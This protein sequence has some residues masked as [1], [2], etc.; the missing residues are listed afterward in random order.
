MD[1]EFDTIQLRKINKFQRLLAMMLCLVMM[2]SLCGADLISIVLAT[3][4]AQQNTAEETRTETR[5]DVK[6]RLMDQ[7]RYEGW[8]PYSSDMTLDEFYALM[9]LFDE[10]KLPLD[11]SV[12]RGIAALG[13]AGLAIDEEPSVNYIPRT[14]FMFR[15]LPLDDSVE[16]QNGDEPISYN[17]VTGYEN[18]LTNYPPGLDNYGSGYQVPPTNWEGVMLGAEKTQVVIVADGQNDDNYNIS[19]NVIQSLFKNYM[20]YGYYVRRVTVEST[21]VAVLGAIKLSGEDGYVYYYLTDENQNTDVST[22]KLED[23]KK[24]I[25]EYSSIE[26]TVQYEVHMDKLDGED[27]TAER[28]DANVLGA[29]LNDTWENIIFGT[30]HLNKTDG[31]AYSFTAYAPYGYTVEFYLVR[32]NEETGTGGSE[33]GEPELLLGMDTAG[34]FT[35]VN[36]GW[37][38]GVEP[39]YYNGSVISDSAAIAPSANGPATLTMSGNIFNNGVHHDRKIIAVVHKNEQPVFLVAPLKFNTNNVSGRGTS[40]TTQVTTAGGETI[41]YDYEDVYLWANG[42]NREKYNLSGLNTTASEG[43][44]RDGNVATNDRWNWSSGG[45]LKDG[46]VY[47][48]EED[49]GTYSYQW[50]WQT[51]DGSGGYTL[52]SLEI[53]GVAVTIPF[54]P[55]QSIRPDYQTGTTGGSTAWYTEAD[56]GNGIHIKVEFLMVFNPGGVAQ[57]VYRITATGARSNVT[58]SAMNLIQ[59]TGADEFVTYHLTGVTDDTGT[60]SVEYYN[61]GE[62]WKSTPQGNIT[63]YQNGTALDLNGDGDHY[64]ANFRFKL[65]DGYT[66]PYYLWEGMQTGEVIQDQASAKRDSD[67]N[68]IL[69]ELNPVISLDGFTGTLDSSNVYGPDA[70]GWYYIRVTTQGGNKVALLTIGAKQLRYVVRYIPNTVEVSNPV[71]VPTFDHTDEPDFEISQEYAEQ[72]DT[73]N[74]SYY[75]VTVDNVIVL[76]DALPSDPSSNYKFVDWV[77][78]DLEGKPITDKQTGAE[79]HYRITHINLLEVV[80][81]AF[82][83]DSL[84][85]AA[86]DIY[87]LR[88]MPKWEPIEH[89]FTYKIALNWVDA[90]GSVH[91]ELYED[92]GS[93]LTDWD[94]ENGPLAV[95]VFKDAAPFKEW[96]LRHPTYSF[97]DAVN[98]ATEKA[99]VTA[100]LDDYVR[101][102]EGVS[103]GDSSYQNILDSLNNM[104]YGGESG[105]PNGTDD[106]FRIG[107]DDPFSIEADDYF[108]I[109]TYASNNESST[110]NGEDDFSRNGSYSFGVYENNGF[111]VIWM[112]E[113]KGYIAITEKG[114]SPNESFLYQIID[115]NGETLTVSVKGGGETFVLAPLGDYT[116]RAIDDWSWRYEDGVC[117][118]STAVPKDGEVALKVTGEHYEKSTAIHADYTNDRNDKMWLGG[119]NSEDNRFGGSSTTGKKQGADSRKTEYVLPTVVYDYG[120][121]KHDEGDD[122]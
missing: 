121:K 87:V 2:F 17:T 89:P 55:K 70:D 15:G 49:D 13:M 92:W 71:G 85:G 25:V 10:G 21:E 43:N 119:E 41:P 19:G 24:F 61:V 90:L 65:V 86:T 56:I 53:N 114:G 107:T 23:G 1:N 28:T 66:S 46:P 103:I 112:Y 59:G 48:T 54:F 79:F 116:I 52:D 82:P 20:P 83:N 9:E 58:I 35:D 50:T 31:G 96:L 102:I 95:K 37:A 110:P 18:D 6:A 68:V 93:S 75:D 73:A 105:T 115:E 109:G 77:L 62:T 104:D 27:V 8:D 76:P 67:G 99:D 117:S 100:A 108:R 26:H 60:A 106:Y 111:I 11:S 97:W 88:L 98:N 12:K 47:M 94:P 36:N 32:T 29:D 39:D 113:D 74:G 30:T 22:T 14:M 63:V 40:A 91:E 69:T 44:L 84:G 16:Y 4:N 7:I 42:S 5:E 101:Y 120:K 33:W 3:E 78:V 51:N 72:Y 118:Q 34:S 38:L 57:R 122:Q 80:D 45:V 64:G 81:Y